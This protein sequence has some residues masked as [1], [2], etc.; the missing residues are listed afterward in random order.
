MKFIRSHASDTLF[1]RETL[2]V[3]RRILNDPRVRNYGDTPTGRFV[4]TSC[5]NWKSWL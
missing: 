1:M 2:P 4:K 5:D 3:A